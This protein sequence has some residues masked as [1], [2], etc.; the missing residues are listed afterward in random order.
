MLSLFPEL[1]DWSW[2]VP[3]IFRIFLGAYLCYNGW[4]IAHKHGHGVSADDR[5]AWLYL[6]VLIVMLGLLFVGG[7][8]I[9]VLGAIGFALALVALFSKHKKHSVAEESFTFYALLALVSLS[10]IFL[11]AGP[12]AFDLPL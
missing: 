4:A 8:Y 9:Q 11:G 12:Y 1:Y 7:I 10:L 6:G 5:R 3:F 2:Y